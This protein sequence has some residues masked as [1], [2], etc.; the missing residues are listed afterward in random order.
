[1]LIPAIHPASHCVCPRF[2]PSLVHEPQVASV[3]LVSRIDDV[4][5]TQ[6]VK[7]Y[8]RGVLW[9][10]RTAR[11]SC[12]DKSTS[13]VWSTTS[14]AQSTKHI[15]DKVC[16]LLCV[17]LVPLGHL[18]QFRPTCSSLCV[19]PCGTDTRMFRL[20]DLPPSKSVPESASPCTRPNFSI[21][22]DYA[23]R[24]L[25][26]SSTPSSAL[27][28]PTLETLSI[29][30][31]GVVLSGPLSRDRSGGA[32]HLARSRPSHFCCISHL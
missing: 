7:R 8:P 26:H 13:S 4:R 17:S 30:L 14:H 22:L 29:S 27:F 28:I 15:A 1:M 21:L 18:C 6:Y 10:G 2:Q 24:S 16:R 11:F 32:P 25:F 31:N 20:A 3:C 12:L 23:D 19:S 9:T 5:L